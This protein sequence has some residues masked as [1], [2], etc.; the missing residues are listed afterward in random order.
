MQDKFVLF[1]LAFSVK[2][3]FQNTSRVYSFTLLFA[4]KVAAER[5]GLVNDT[6]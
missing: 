6:S 5:Q 1:K 2:N 4:A 3:R